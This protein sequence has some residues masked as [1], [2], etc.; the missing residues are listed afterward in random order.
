MFGDFPIYYISIHA[1]RVGSDANILPGQIISIHA[2]RPG[3]DVDP[4]YN[5][6]GAVFLFTSPARVTTCAGYF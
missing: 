2:T 4:R 3:S 5:A 6:S 1:A